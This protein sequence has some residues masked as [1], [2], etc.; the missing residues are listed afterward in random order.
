MAKLLDI[1][2]IETPRS[3]LEDTYG[4]MREAGRDGREAIVLWAGVFAG[5][6]TF[7]VTMI[8]RPAQTTYRGAHGLLAAV[9]GEELFRMN[10]A[11]SENNVRLLAQLH[12]HPSGAYHSETDDQFAIVT[13][14]GSLSIVVPDF[15]SGRASVDEWA[16]F[17]LAAPGQW[18]E[19]PFDD[20]ASLFHVNEDA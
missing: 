2:R 6:M 8:L 13:A 12:S 20:V 14:R 7:L 4:F 11:L 10:R 18:T 3:L 15:A 17:R 19:L 1:V 5:P 16:V 9:S